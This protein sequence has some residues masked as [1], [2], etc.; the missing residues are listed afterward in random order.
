M[1]WHHFVRIA[2]LKVDFS[3]SLQQKDAWE[4]LATAK[5]QHSWASRQ[6]RMGMLVKALEIE[7][8][9]QKPPQ[10][11]CTLPELEASCNIAAIVLTF[12]DATT[13]QRGTE[14]RSIIS[15]GTHPRTFQGLDRCL[16][17]PLPSGFVM[18]PGWTVF[19]AHACW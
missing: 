6:L 8:P 3:T 9:A 14:Q 11:Y 13:A 16:Q 12:Y 4:S 17:G 18:L 15:K 2:H 1:G 19:P 10:V 5:L 7:V